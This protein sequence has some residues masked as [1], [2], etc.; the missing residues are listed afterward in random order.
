MAWLVKNYYHYRTVFSHL[1]AYHECPRVKH[2]AGLFKPKRI[3]QIKTPHIY[4]A[5]YNAVYGLPII[6]RGIRRGLKGDSQK[7]IWEIKEILQIIPTQWCW[8]AW[9]KCRTLRG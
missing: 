5:I 9:R 6:F 3:G 1:P 4:A 2:G 8:G 7:F